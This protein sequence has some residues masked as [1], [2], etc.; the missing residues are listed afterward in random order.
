M[1]E[2]LEVTP[3][4]AAQRAKW[5][6]DGTTRPDFAESVTKGVES[7]WDY[8]RPPRIEPVAKTLRV[9]VAGR[10]VA[11]T[12]NGVRVCET[13]GAPTYY[14]PPEDVAVDSLEP[15]GNRSACEWK[16]VAEELGLESIAPAAWRYV[17]V[18]AEY[19]AL[20]RWVAF[21]PRALECYVGDERVTAQPG[22]DYGGWVTAGLA[23]P[24]KGPPGSE[25]W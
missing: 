14:F 3:S 20:Y 11:A 13:A 1:V 12:Q 23:G 7:V 16:G 6:Y 22:D 17:E 15:T 9:R 19:R 21:Y 2:I 5:R 10:L 25:N 4:V 8:P 24:I 18:F